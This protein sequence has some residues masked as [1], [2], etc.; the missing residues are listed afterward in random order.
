MKEKECE[1]CGNYFIAL[2]NEKYCE[3]CNEE[4]KINEH[5]AFICDNCGDIN[6][7]DERINDIKEIERKKVLEQVEDLLYS[8]DIDWGSYIEGGEEEFL[9][10][11]SKSFI[12][13]E[14][15]QKLEEIGK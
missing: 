5:Y 6:N 8:N 10:F 12:E 2:M 13:K 15:K 7:I 14:L 9:V 4:A 11:D 3:K 1:K